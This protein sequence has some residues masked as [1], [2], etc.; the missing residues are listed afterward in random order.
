MHRASR[1][2]PILPRRVGRRASAAT[3]PPAARHPA[4]ELSEP[5]AAMRGVP[6]G[7]VMTNTSEILTGAR[8]MWELVDR[9]AE[10]S[11]DHPMLI[12]ADGETVT[13]GQFRD[14]AERV[15]AGLARHGRHGPARSSPGSSRPGS[16]PSS[17]PSPWPGSAPSRTR[18]STSTASAEVGLRPA[19]DRRRALRHPRHLAGHRLRRHRR[20]R[21]RG[22]PRRARP[23]SRTDDG[24]PGG[25][26][27]GPAP[28]TRRGRRRRT[29][30][31]AGSTTRPARPPT[32]R[33]SSTPT[34]R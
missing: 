13:F 2:A 32:P 21:P 16:T 5:P 4:P 6:E 1:H 15:A 23:S 28:A 24:L 7:G 30:R 22:R 12:A 14:R 29:P 25:G 19:P 3:E 18:S 10:A 27:G 17:C 11:P 31:S 33:A 34:R 8:T 9:R 26:P 20:A